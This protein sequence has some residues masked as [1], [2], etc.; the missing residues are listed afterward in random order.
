M[1][2]AGDIAVR[3]IYFFLFS[4]VLNASTVFAEARIEVILSENTV[5][6]RQVAE[7]VQRHLQFNS[8][9]IWSVRDLDTAATGQ[10]PQL[11][12]AIGT[13]AAQELAKKPQPAPV[14]C[15][16]LPKTAYQEISFP[17]ETLHSA[18]F[19][20]QPLS[21]LFTLTEK[22]L[23]PR[24]QVAIITSANTPYS[25]QRLEKS[26]QQA[27][28]HLHTHTL[29]EN[30]N[31]LE[32]LDP[33]FRDADAFLALPDQ[34]A[35]SYATVK[36]ILYLSYKY[37]KPVVGFSEKFTDAGALISLYA[38]PEDVGEDTAQIIE[39]WL[40]GAAK[41]LP[42]PA[43]GNGFSLSINKAIARGLNM[44]TQLDPIQLK[45]ELMEELRND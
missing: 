17:P 9:L 14:L 41:S 18:L 10:S 37:R 8:N 12:V 34:S 21:R 32:A 42:P 45:R 39:T 5:V 15:I 25:P 31:P 19:L 38:S 29:T 24:N 3:I 33:L 30:E 26:A 23:S 27:G 7:Q 1:C 6:Y 16:F 20:D 43:Y 4:V 2:Q 13:R 44:E 40:Q 28:L 22:I 11:L 35:L 36:W